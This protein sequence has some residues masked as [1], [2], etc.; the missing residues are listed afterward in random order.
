MCCQM[1]NIIIL[2]HLRVNHIALL[3]AK[4]FTGGLDSRQLKIIQS[5]RPTSCTVL[6][7]V[8][9]PILKI[10]HKLFKII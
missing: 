4:R 9:C 8:L 2:C 1:M 3:Q 6:A 5:Y 10:S 7:I